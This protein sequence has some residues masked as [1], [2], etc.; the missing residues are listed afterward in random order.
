MMKRWLLFLIPCS[1]AAA[2]VGATGDTAFVDKHDAVVDEA[3]AASRHFAEADGLFAEAVLHALELG[4]LCGDGDALASV[5]ANAISALMDATPRLPEIRESLASCGADTGDSTVKSVMESVCPPSAETVSQLVKKLDESGRW[6]DVDYM[7]VSRS[8]WPVR[9]HLQRMKAIARAPHSAESV[10]AFRRALGA[11]LRGGFRNPN[12]WWNAIGVPLELG[13]ACLA[14][15]GELSDAERAAVVG[16]LRES[17]IGMTGQNRIWLAECVLYRALIEGNAVDAKAACDA[18]SGEV[19]MSDTVEGIQA[20][21]SFHQHGNQAQFG[22]YGASYIMSVP[23]LLRLFDGT[24]WA[25]DAEKTEIL[26]N[27]VEKGF[28]PTVWHGSMD[29]GAIGR[30][31]GRGAARA[32]GASVLLAAEELGVGASVAPGLH[33]FPKSAYGVYRADSWMASVKCQTAS[34]QGME[35]V[36]EDNLLGAHLADG[37]LFCYVTG[38]EYR[39]IFP[40][41]NWRHVPG[42]TSYDIETVDW[43]SRNSEECC[44]A[45]GD[46]VRFRLDR[47]G[48]KAESEWRFSPNGVDVSVSGITATNGLPVVTTV[49]QSVAQPNATW[50]REGGGI[51]AVNGAIRYLLPSNAVVKVEDR[52]GSWRRHMGAADDGEV[53][54]RAFE[55]TIPHGVDPTGAKC[56]WRVEF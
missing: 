43:E 13:A 28:L 38:E 54:G 5:K 9:V 55:I 15:D 4:A 2:H 34:I 56:R 19:A 48:L 33:W 10:A 45:E 18:I 24:A 42:T 7:T 37:A 29:V 12:W 27:L 52:T 32:K 22:N 16:R 36:N 26:R 53:Q 51:V 50:W 39:D 40:F 30:Q 20:D 6:P 46:L 1:V 25:A 8:A 44:V 17:K 3:A 49:E 21:W 23:R 31:L 14:M 47:A 11:W 41:W 35:K